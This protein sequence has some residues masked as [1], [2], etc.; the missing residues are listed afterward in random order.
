MQL[1][2]RLDGQSRI[3]SSFVG[4]VL[5]CLRGAGLREEALRLCQELQQKQLQLDQQLLGVVLSLC[6]RADLWPTALS[7]FSRR[8]DGLVPRGATITSLATAG[9]W[10]WCC[11]LLGLAEVSSPMANALMDALA[12][13]NNWKTSI[14][15]LRQLAPDGPWPEV[16]TMNSAVAS[17]VGPKGPK[18]STVIEA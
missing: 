5:A 6:D 2:D 7:I 18:W 9:R 12:K 13:A 10:R 15:Q 11:R 3:N 8:P 1:F 16:S 4:N 14:A 17:M